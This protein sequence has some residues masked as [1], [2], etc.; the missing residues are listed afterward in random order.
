MCYARDECCIIVLL[1]QS[2]KASDATGIATTSS[3]TSSSAASA[4]AAA[5]TA[6]LSRPLSF[7]RQKSTG[8]VGSTSSGKDEQLQQQ[9]QQQQGTDSSA[10]KTSKYTAHDDTCAICLEQYI[11]GEHLRVLPCQVSI[12]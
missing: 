5:F 2:G 8:S 11:P 1:E 6:T 12:C 4:A 7:K 9:Q 3:S 10:M